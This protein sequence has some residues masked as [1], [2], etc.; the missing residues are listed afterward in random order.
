VQEVPDPQAVGFDLGDQGV[1][2]RGVAGRHR[3]HRVERGENLRLSRLAPVA[4][5]DRHRR[6]R[7][8]HLPPGMA[9]DQPPGAL[10]VEAG[11]GPTDLGVVQQFPIDCN[12]S[13]LCR[14]QL[15]GFSVRL[16][17]SIHSRRRG[18]FGVAF[19]GA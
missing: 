2:G 7:I 1:V 17:A 16:P 15:R 12:C 8:D 9:V 18:G 10:V 14:R 5:Q 4:H 19:G 13:S 6:L 3:A 11:P